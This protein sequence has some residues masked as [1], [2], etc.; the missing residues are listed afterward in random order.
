MNVNMWT[1]PGHAEHLER[2]QSRGIEIIEPEEGELACNWEGKGR[3]APIEQIGE[4]ALAR[5]ED[6]G[7]MSG[8]RVVVTAGPTR[9]ALDPVRYLTNHSSGKMGI[10]IAEAARDRGA[11][12][13]LVLGPVQGTPPAGVSIVPVD[14]ALEMQQAVNQAARRAHAVVM[15]R[16]LPITGPRR[17]QNKRLPAKATDCSSTSS[18]RPTF[19]RA[20]RAA[21]AG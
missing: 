13:T 15:R 17:S 6:R 10:G 21:R 16:P 20:C 14:S 18:R 2:L 11:D 19:S 9:E 7:R 4:R 8:K 5:L 1:H 3:L 12:V